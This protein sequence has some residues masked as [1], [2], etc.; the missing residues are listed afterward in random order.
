MTHNYNSF[1]QFLYQHDILQLLHHK[2]PGKNLGAFISVVPILLLMHFIWLSQE[3]LI[4]SHVLRCENFASHIG[5]SVN[6]Y[7]YL[8]S[9]SMVTSK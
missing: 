7:Y 8:A 1:L 2:S 9:Y 5:L 6:P 3:K 4:L